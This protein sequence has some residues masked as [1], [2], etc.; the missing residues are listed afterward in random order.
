MEKLILI[1]ERAVAL[2]GF[3]LNRTIS[4]LIIESA[5][6]V[7]RLSNKPLYIVSTSNL[8]FTDFNSDHN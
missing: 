8:P 3:S 7:Y 1:T 6:K 4:L 5:Y 2:I